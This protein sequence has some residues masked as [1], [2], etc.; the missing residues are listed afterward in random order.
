MKNKMFILFFLKNL[1]LGLDQK[2]LELP[3]PKSN[4]R[5]ETKFVQREK[6]SL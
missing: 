6:K 2:A 5:C 4:F 3:V 1:L